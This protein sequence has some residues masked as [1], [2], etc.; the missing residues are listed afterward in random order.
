MVLLE[1][2][3]A[4]FSPALPDLVAET[5]THDADERSPGRKR[6]GGRKQARNAPSLVGRDDD[7]GMVTFVGASL[8]QNIP[9]A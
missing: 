4:E 6:Q 1:R 3:L 2:R 5:T 7:I 8:L 9:R